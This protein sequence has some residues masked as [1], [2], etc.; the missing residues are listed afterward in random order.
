MDNTNLEKWIQEVDKKLDNHLVH[1]AADISQIKNDL[2]WIKQFFWLISG[3]SLS[4]ILG[5]LA[6]L[7]YK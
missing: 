3:I 6:S 4:S 1:T 5:L 7:L 2:A